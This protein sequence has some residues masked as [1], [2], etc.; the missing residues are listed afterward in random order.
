MQ[1]IAVQDLYPTPEK[2]YDLLNN[3]YLQ[4]SQDCF[5]K[6]QLDHVLNNKITKTVGVEKELEHEH[7]L[8]AVGCFKANVFCND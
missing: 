4:L 1:S 6:M 5:R 2:Q 7:I 8:I 3:K